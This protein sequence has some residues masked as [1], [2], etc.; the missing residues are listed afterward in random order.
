[1][2][3]ALHQ[4]IRAFTVVE[5]M[6]VVTIISLLAGI[7]VP[8]YTRARKRAQAT[9][10]LEDLRMLDYALDR[11]AIDNNKSLGDIAAL[12]DLQPYIKAGS[13]LSQGSDILGNS[14]GNAFSVDSSPRIPSGTYNLLS[15]VVAPAFW[16]PYY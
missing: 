16:S 12:S 13:K 9:R 2:N 15:D 5:L 7:A 1:M 4:N 14:Y 10:V 11:W 6:I 8:S 3:S